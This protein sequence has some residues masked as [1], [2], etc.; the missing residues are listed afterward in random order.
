V[1]NPTFRPN[2]VPSYTADDTE[3]AVDTVYSAIADASAPEAQHAAAK[4]IE[5]AM[6]VDVATKS[7]QKPALEVGLVAE[8]PLAVE[9]TATRDY[10]Y[11]QAV[12]GLTP[13]TPTAYV[14]V[15]PTA[16]FNG[17]DA[18]SAGH[19]V[20]TENDYSILDDTN[21]LTKEP[22]YVEALSAAPPPRDYEYAQA[23]DGLAPGASAAYL[24]VAPMAP[25]DASSSMD[26]PTSSLSLVATYPFA[27][28]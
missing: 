7:T 6:Y 27:R 5:D 20:V 23:V 8:Q 4:P 28:A 17:T 14:N 18:S 1:A 10:E 15:V 19:A 16:L 2:S 11:A 12:A 9:P 21:A 25:F 24:D 22:M 3:A 13:G 26:R